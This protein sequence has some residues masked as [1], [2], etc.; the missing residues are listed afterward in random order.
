MSTVSERNRNVF[1][2]TS[3]SSRHSLYPITF[4]L[5]IISNPKIIQ[6]PLIFILCCQIHI[7]QISFFIAPFFRSTI[8]EN[9][10]IILDDEWNDIMIQALRKHNQYAHMAIAVLKWMDPLKLYM[11]VQHIFKGLFF[12]SVVLCQ[13][14]FHLIGNFFR[15]CSIHTATSFGIFY[16][17]QPQTNLFWNRW[18]HFSGLDEALS[19]ISPLMLPLRCQ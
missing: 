7:C 15:K 8:I 2:I 11:E 19:S 4:P 13:Q 16:N 1:I 14:I 10:Q 18:F 5:F 17:R 9:F 3:A 12:F 6:I